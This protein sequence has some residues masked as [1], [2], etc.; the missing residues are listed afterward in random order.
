M[1]LLTAGQSRST[2]DEEIPS[3]E[4]LTSSD[5]TQTIELVYNMPHN[6][7]I[8]RMA[9]QPNHQCNVMLQAIDGLRPEQ[10]RLSSTDAKDASKANTITGPITAMRV[11][12]DGR[13]V[14]VT[15]LTDADGVEEL[16]RLEYLEVK[17]GDADFRSHA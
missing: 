12:P 2:C 5:R 3:S 1:K 4:C 17:V 15:L 6:V 14:R 13:W 7:F 10:W 16:K 11:S 8:S 9:T